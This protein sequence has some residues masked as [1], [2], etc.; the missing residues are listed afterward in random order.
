MN[1]PVGITA[2]TS[3][4]GCPSDRNRWKLTNRIRSHDLIGVRHDQFP[5]LDSVSGVITGITIEIPVDVRAQQECYRVKPASMPG[6]SRCDQSRPTSPS[7][8]V[9]IQDNVPDAAGQKGVGDLSQDAAGE[10]SN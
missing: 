10:P 6:P 5:L 7:R 4:S 9:G 2:Y 3:I 8:S 1:S